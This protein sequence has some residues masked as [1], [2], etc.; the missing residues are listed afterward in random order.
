MIHEF[1]KNEA[2]ADLQLLSH[3]V[4]HQLFFSHKFGWKFGITLN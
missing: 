1:K 2:I 4:I 3:T